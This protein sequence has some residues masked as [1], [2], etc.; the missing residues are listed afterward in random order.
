MSQSIFPTRVLLLAI[1][2]VCSQLPIWAL[3]VVVD[4]IL[5]HFHTTYIIKEEGQY[6]SQYSLVDSSLIQTLG[7]F[8]LVSNAANEGKGCRLRSTSPSSIKQRCP[9]GFSIENRSITCILPHLV[10]RIKAPVR[11]PSSKNGTIASLCLGP[12]PQMSFSRLTFWVNLSKTPPKS[13]IRHQ[14]VKKIGK[15]ELTRFP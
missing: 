3:N 11:F 10:A 4:I 14:R 9:N 7:R 15:K 13:W 2:F 6:A 5:A 8:D 1:V 12:Q